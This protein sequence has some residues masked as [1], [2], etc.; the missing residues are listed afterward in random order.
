MIKHFIIKI[1]RFYYILIVILLTSCDFN[2]KTTLFTKIESVHSD[3]NFN[4]LIAPFESDSLNGL[5]YDILFNGGGIG[6]GDFNNDGYQ[7]IFFAGNLVSSKLYLNLGNFK[8]TDVTID[9]GLQTDRWCTG[10]SVA[11]I[12]QDGLL[13]IYV[14]VSNPGA[15]SE[16]RS[17]LLFINKGSKDGIPKFEEMGVKYKLN[18]D[19][20]SVQASFF[21]YDKDGDLDC[22]LLTNAKESERNRLTKKKNDGKGLSNDKLYENIGK[23]KDHLVFRNVSLEAGITKEGHG[24]GLC[25]SDLNQDGWLDIYCANDFVSN[26]L[27]W[28][29]NKNG[30]F[31]DKSSDFLTHTSFNS[32]GVDI[33]DFNNDSRPDICVLDMLPENE[34]RRKMMVMKTNTNYFTV[35]ESLGYQDEYVRNVLQLNQDKN[36]VGNLKFSEIGQLSG[37]HATDWSWAP[38]IADFDN[39]GF[40]DLFISNGF[41]RDITNL[42][43]V[44]YLNQPKALNGKSGKELQNERVQ[45]LYKLPEVKLNNY[46]YRNNG[47]LTFKDVSIAWGFEEKTYSNGAAYADFDN[48]GDLDLVFNNIDDKASLYRNNL[49]SSDFLKENTLINDTH[50][51]RFKLISD[52]KINKNVGAKVYVILPSGESLYQENLS[53]RGYMSS[54]DPVLF[55]GLGNHT[56]IKVKIVWADDKI[57]IIDNLEVDT[58]HEIQYKPIEITKKNNS[59]TAQ[60]FK[61]LNVDSLGLTFEHQEYEFDEFR[62]TPSLHQ[63]YNKNSPGLAIGDVDG[64]GFDD[65]F[66][67]ADPSHKRSIFLQKESGEFKEL[68]QGENNQED[69]G[70]LLF[71][72]DKD[73]DLDLYVVSGGSTRARDQSSIFQDRLYLND[74]TGR[75]TRSKDR[76]PNTIF[77]GSTIVA[78]DFDHDGDLDLFRGGRV[79]VG[80]FPM[81]PESYLFRNDNGVFKD[82]TDEVATDLRKVGMVTSALWTDYNQDGWFD[83]I[84][85]G[86]FMPITFYLNKKGKLIKD[87]NATILKSEGWWNSITSGDFDLDGDM[88]YILGNLGLNSQYK[89]SLK[90]PLNLYAFDYDNNGIIDPIMTYFKEGKEVPIIVRD[91]MFDQ[92]GFLMRKRF[93]SYSSY[94]KATIDNVLTKKEIKISKILS[95]VEMRSCLL[96]NTGDGKFIL[97]PLPLEAQFSP[98]FGSLAED[99]NRDGFLDVLLVGNSDAFDTYT[100][101]YNASLGTLLLGNGV[102]DFT[103]V[104]QNKSGLYLEGDAKALGLLNTRK[105]LLIVVTKNNDA[106]QLLTFENNKNI[107]N[108]S[109]TYDE[110]IADVLFKNGK[111]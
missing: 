43:Y 12:N 4:N 33:Q 105:G 28:I 79:S 30:T 71:D 95:A 68:I 52:N 82:V 49:I 78:A 65:V 97:K 16:K 42:D 106:T 34:E 85:V 98:V 25:V 84:V 13:D 50:Y 46:L 101:S 20:F 59:K 6:I 92:L 87:D 76:I 66:I 108:I 1:I 96:E 81:T 22:Y 55:F 37:I 63:Q 69:L 75:M 11:D 91:V 36:N 35:A 60:I 23:V 70:S 56:S 74:G 73:G 99:F 8:F 94:A 44:A 58:L 109:L 93:N 27:I 38:L 10:V 61:Q 14:C 32:M 62:F 48:D 102:G 26:D 47:D 100:G 110:V 17:N 15:S 21:D 45:K 103:Y 31:V 86:E 57:Q 40:K 54:V 18:D 7:D 39:D 29:N 53:V 2:E 9:S 72:A 5:E 64:N 90:E 24:L 83:L 67:G 19:G 41:R 104:P 107:E 111:L 89:S 51:I 3:I 77:S 88:D 80:E